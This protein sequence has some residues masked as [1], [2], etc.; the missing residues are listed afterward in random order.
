MKEGFGFTLAVGNGEFWLMNRYDELHSRATTTN[1][2]WGYLPDP[3]VFT[4]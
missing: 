1:L 3:P 4:A 2:L